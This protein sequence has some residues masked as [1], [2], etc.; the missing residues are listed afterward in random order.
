MFLGGALEKRDAFLPHIDDNVPALREVS[1][2]PR[3]D[4]PFVATSE[5]KGRRP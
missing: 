3:N 2:Q 5:S 1:N 4:E